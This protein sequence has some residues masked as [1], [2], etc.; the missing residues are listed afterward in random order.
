MWRIPRPGTSSF[1]SEAVSAVPVLALLQIQQQQQVNGITSSVATVILDLIVGGMDTLERQFMVV[2][3]DQQTP[4]SLLSPLFLDGSSQGPGPP[5]TLVPST[6]S[7]E[8]P[9]GRAFLGKI[10]GGRAP[11]VPVCNPAISVTRDYS[12]MAF[13]HSVSA[14]GGPVHP[15]QGVLPL[16]LPPGFVMSVL[17]TCLGRSQ[18]NVGVTWVEVPI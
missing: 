14:G 18:L 16:L 4:A 15:L 13:G 5:I 7:T 11:S 1:L 17:D 8:Q 6:I 12:G 10:T 2:R 9:L 3:F